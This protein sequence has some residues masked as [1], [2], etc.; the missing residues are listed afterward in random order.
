MTKKCVINALRKLKDQQPK[1]EEEKRKK[2]KTL[3][4]LVI[5]EICIKFLFANGGG[6]VSN[7][8]INAIWGNIESCGLAKEVGRF[9]SGS[10]RQRLKSKGKGSS[11]LNTEGYAHLI[12]V[13]IFGN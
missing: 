9:L 3:V 8:L 12:L 2:R 11:G 10:L 7:E 5:L 13:C 4:R 1:N 6:N